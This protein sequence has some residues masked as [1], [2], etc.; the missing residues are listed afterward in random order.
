MKDLPLNALRAFATVFAHGGVRAAARELGTAHSSVSRHL[1]ELEDFLGVTLVSPGGGR[2]PLAFSP[3]GE[4][5]ARAILRGLEEVQQAVTSLQEARSHGS[6]SIGTASS[7]AVRWLLPKLPRFETS[8]PHVEVSVVV[9]SGRG[10]LRAGGGLD[11]VIAMGPGP[12]RDVDCRP[13]ANDALF[14]VMS[15]AFW[16]KSGRPCEPS[17]LAR[18]RLL[19]DRDP[20]A[21]WA[22]WKR[23][24]GPEN[25]DV[26]KGPRFTSTDLVLRAA[27]L[28]QGVALARRQLAAD[29][30]E[31]GLLHRPIPDL[32]VDL[33]HAYWILRPRYAPARPAV[34]AVI[35]W[36]EREASMPQYNSRADTR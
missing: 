32:T 23:A 25:L 4:E 9:D 8:H 3:Q 5:L 19:H 7:F 24:H 2:R 34:D 22:I 6:V 29:D 18:L 14:P 15:P 31:S 20:H 16:E 26:R 12:Y 30:L 27:A 33:G 28:G 1:R 11:L 36:L 17:D 13:L 21:S 35:A 10:G